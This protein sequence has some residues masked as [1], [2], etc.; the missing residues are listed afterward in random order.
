MLIPMWGKARFGIAALL[1]FVAIATAPAVQCLGFLTS[2]S[3]SHSCCHPHG[4]PGRTVAPACCVH[5]PAITSSDVEVRAPNAAMA[6]PV[7]EFAP[8]LSALAA[9]SPGVPHLD[10]SPPQLNS[11]LRI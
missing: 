11:I 6:A 9:E 2:N 10:T 4:T 5:S 8:L 7:V 3:H 1:M